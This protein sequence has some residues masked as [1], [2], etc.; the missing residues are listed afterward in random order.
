MQ[1]YSDLNLNNNFLDNRI[2]KPLSDSTG[3]IVL[4]SSINGV[5]YTLTQNNTN[6]TLPD[7]STLQP[8]WSIILNNYTWSVAV[9]GVSG[10][11]DYIAYPFK[12]QNITAF[13]RVMVRLAQP[14]YFQVTPINPYDIINFSVP[15]NYIG[16]TDT[17]ICNNLPNFGAPMMVLDASAIVN[18]MTGI[19]T[20]PQLSIGMNSVDNAIANTITISSS[21]SQGNRFAINSVYP[22]NVGN[23]EIYIHV[24]QAAVGTTMNGYITFCMSI[25]SSNIG[26]APTIA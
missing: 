16:A 12:S 2:A 25:G 4:T 18:T 19:T 10:S 9:I 14:N 15:F 21:G 17:I 7:S 24:V 26:P 1:I 6:I 23:S 8:G 3:T 22:G 5:E 20:N 11:G 13:S